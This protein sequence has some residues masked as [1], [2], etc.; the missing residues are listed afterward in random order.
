MIV[1]TTRVLRMR[2]DGGDCESTDV[3]DARMRMTLTMVLRMF[4]TRIMMTSS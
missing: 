4:T 1:I 3:D 2:S